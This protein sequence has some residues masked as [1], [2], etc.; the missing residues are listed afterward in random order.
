LSADAISLGL[1]LAAGL[2]SIRDRRWPKGDMPTNV[3]QFF[4]DASGTLQ[5]I[6]YVAAGDANIR[7]G[8]QMMSALTS[9]SPI[10]S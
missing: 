4:A 3:A 7:T 6:T 9:V 8:A 5:A 2:T 10:V 1:Q